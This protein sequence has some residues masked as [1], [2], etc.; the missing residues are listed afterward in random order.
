MNNDNLQLILDGINFLKGQNEEILK[1][2]DAV[3]IRLDSIEVRMDALENRMNKIEAR[4]DKLE[5]KIDKVEARLGRVE[6]KLILVEQRLF[7]V[8]KT[9]HNVVV[10]VIDHRVNIS[11]LVNQEQFTEFR[12]LNLKFH[13]DTK[14]ALV[15]L[16]HEM[17]S[18][19]ESHKNV[20]ERVAVLEL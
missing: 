10:E 6:S 3:E 15:R 13:D 5:R 19:I 16:E 1:R 14:A 17:K 12:S 20:A 4:M 8:E 11:N 2:L 18:L 7:D 9:L